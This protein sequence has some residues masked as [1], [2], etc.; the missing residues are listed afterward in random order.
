VVLLGLFFL[1]SSVLVAAGPIT[2]RAVAAVLLLIPLGGPPASAEEAPQSPQ[3]EAALPNEAGSEQPST[4]ESEKPKLEPE[5]PRALYNLG[6]AALDR[7]ERDE[8]TRLLEK[9]RAQAGADGELRFRASYNLGMAEAA[10]AEALK[11]ERP[12]EALAS[13]NRAAAWFREAIQQRRDQEDARHNLEVTMRRALLLEDRLAQEG[14]ADLEQELANMAD[15]QRSLV[16]ETADLLERTDSEARS[17]PHAVDRYR[18]EF[19]GQA[20]AQRALVSDADALAE[21]IAAEWGALESRSEKER[22]PEERMRTVQLAAVLE[23]LHPARE[24]MGQ[25]R[26]Q[27]RRRQGERAYRR[28]AAAL[29][30][31]KR[32]R[33]PLR[34]PVSLLD[35]VIGD[36]SEV[37]AATE[38]LAAAGREIPGLDQPLA[39]PAWL[40]REALQESQTA[41][42]ER[43]SELH[44]RLRAGLDSA[45]PRTDPGTSELLVRVEE[46][47]PVVDE[48]GEQLEAA[49]VEIERG[50]LDTARSAQREAI[51]A[52]LEARERFLDLRGLIEA[53]YAAQRRIQGVLRGARWAPLR[54]DRKLRGRCRSR[55]SGCDWLARHSR[56]RSRRWAT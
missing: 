19:A 5:E 10:S 37:A 1:V 45:A 35:A 3:A 50:A 2:R 23:H 41:V 36:A 39:P 52:L 25:A 29:Q 9:A 34:D 56:G 13:L 16:A 48:A 28:S 8:A 43:T 18:R 14:D 40:S 26:R 27:L 15:R 55:R 30:A 46:A 11:A 4:E 47:E 51:V 38:L 54:R 6:V 44:A 32:A 17:D 20:T 33:D 24:R 22:T 42:A 53:T 12:V 31:L 7:N 21:R 49:S